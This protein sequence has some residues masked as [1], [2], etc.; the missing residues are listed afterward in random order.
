[1]YGYSVVHDYLDLDL[2]LK[3]T[4]SLYMENTNLPLPT[5]EEVLLCNLDTTAEEVI[6]IIV[7]KHC[8]TYVSS[9]YSLQDCTKM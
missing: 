6:H 7:D 2:I 5:P 9:V 4:L 1:M 8:C 3:S